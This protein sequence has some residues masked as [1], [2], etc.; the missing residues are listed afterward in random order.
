MGTMS[1]KSENPRIETTNK[2]KR[3]RRM[4]LGGKV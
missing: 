2:K 1:Q 3:G 4:V